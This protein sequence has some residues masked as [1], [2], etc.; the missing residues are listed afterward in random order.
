ML[1]TSILNVGLKADKYIFGKV[2]N[3]AGKGEITGKKASLFPTVVF[4][5]GKKKNAFA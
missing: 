5:N 2:G 4:E 3:I 1:V